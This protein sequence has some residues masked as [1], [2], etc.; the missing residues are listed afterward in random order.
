MRGLPCEHVEVLGE[1]GQ[2]FEAVVVSP[3]FAGKRLVE[4]HKLVYQALGTHMREEIH[5]LSLTT[6]TPDA[7]ARLGKA[8]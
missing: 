5:A 1:D 2:H 3:A 4:Q 7:W 6:Y 8:E